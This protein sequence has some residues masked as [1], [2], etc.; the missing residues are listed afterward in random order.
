MSAAGTKLPRCQFSTR[1]RH[2]PV[3]NWQ[4]YIYANTRILISSSSFSSSSSRPAAPPLLLRAVDVAPPPRRSSSVP[5][6]R[7]R[8]GRHSSPAWRAFLPAR[9][10]APP[11]PPP[12]G[13]PTPAPR[14]SSA[15]PS[16]S[17][18]G[19]PRRPGSAASPRRAR[20]CLP[21]RPRPRPACRRRPGRHALLLREPPPRHPCHRPA[22]APSSSTSAS[23]RAVGRRHAGHIDGR[24]PWNQVTSAHPGANVT[25]F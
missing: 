6:V 24:T 15:P 13:L 3:L 22:A 10:S 1:R 25:F 23:I 21:C 17:R 20:A 14:S 16:S 11:A 19:A 5:W 12:P 7:L 2:G 18:A 9:S 8:G 4:S